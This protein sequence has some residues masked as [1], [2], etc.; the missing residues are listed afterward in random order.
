M[1][2]V[3]TAKYLIDCYDIPKDRLH[4]VTLDNQTP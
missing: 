4:I 3:A 1:I 2:L